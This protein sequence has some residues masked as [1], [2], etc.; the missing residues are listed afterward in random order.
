MYDEL[1]QRFGPDEKFSAMLRSQKQENFKLGN[2]TP[3]M[4]ILPTNPSNHAADNEHKEDL[5]KVEVLLVS[6]IPETHRSS[7]H[8][9]I[10]P[11]NHS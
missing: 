10:I 4:E 7:Y 1:V 9:L 2:R 5:E 3:N 6:Q 8:S 11:H